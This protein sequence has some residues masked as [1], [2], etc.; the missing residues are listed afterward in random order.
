ML[1]PEDV[2]ISPPHKLTTR[3]SKSCSLIFSRSRLF[4]FTPF[5]A[6]SYDLVTSLGV[7]SD[8]IISLLIPQ[9]RTMDSEDIENGPVKTFVDEGV[10]PNTVKTVD[11]ST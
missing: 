1:R 8:L 2:S 11:G 6:T 10:S 7:L 3:A 9:S 5:Q 4:L